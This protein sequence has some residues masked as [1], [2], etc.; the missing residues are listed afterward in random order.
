MPDLSPALTEYLDKIVP[1]VAAQLHR[2]YGRLPA[3][4]IAQELYARVLQRPAW[5]AS[6][7]ERG[8]IGLMREELRRAGW[9]ACKDDERSERAKRA[10]A[11]GYDVDDEQFYTLPL[12][13]ALLP[14][15][16]DGGIAEEPP[17]QT[18]GRAASLKSERGDYL[19]MMVDIGRGM[20]RIRP[21]E[22]RTIE[23][24]FSL[25]QGDDSDSRFARSRLASSQG[26][27]LNALEQRVTRALRALQA[28]LGGD[29]PWH[30]APVSYETASDAGRTPHGAPS[31]SR[32]EARKAA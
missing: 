5:F 22:R 10:A 27:A 14:P 2:G 21:H 24:W 3:E 1:H 9:R 20:E 19:T 30:R 16:L 29:N 32:R 4:D 11:A 13:R 15:F 12:L 6:L 18:G 23:Q 25:P 26:V 17:R 28:Q 8:E 31:R 7:L